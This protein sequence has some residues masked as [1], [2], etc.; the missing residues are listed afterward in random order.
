MKKTLAIVG[1]VCSTI[2]AGAQNW[3]VTEFPELASKQAMMS[4]QLAFAKEIRITLD[5]K[6][7]VPSGTRSVSVLYDSDTPSFKGLCERIRRE[8]M[9]A[10]ITG[11]NDY[12]TVTV[13]IFAGDGTL[14]F[15]AYKKKYISFSKTEGRHI[16]ENAH[17]SIELPRWVTIRVPGIESARLFLLDGNVVWK[18]RAVFPKSEY[19]RLELGRHAIGK[20]GGQLVLKW[21]GIEGE[22]IV[23]LETGKTVPMSSIVIKTDPSIEDFAVL[24]SNPEIVGAFQIPYATREKFVAEFSVTDVSRDIF[25]SHVSGYVMTIDSTEKS[26]GE[27]GDVRGTTVSRAIGMYLKKI[28]RD[29]TPREY[30]PFILQSF[31][32]SNEAENSH[33]FNLMK[34]LEPG[35]YHVSY[36]WQDILLP[37]L[38]DIVISHN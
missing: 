29:R 19:N 16:N 17:I 23:D 24:S 36:K 3:P 26:E 25:F 6:T 37:D 31:R 1:L 30:H 10:S 5:C 21:K 33:S 18:E 4:Y 34:N 8:V 38:G 13:N 12:V 22:Q 7:F 32:G 15:T 28:S 9:T 14:L 27:S 20:V 2:F 11:A 35:V